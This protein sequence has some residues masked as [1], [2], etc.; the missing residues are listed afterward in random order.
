MIR[1]ARTVIVGLLML[2]AAPLAACAAERGTLEIVTRS[3]VQVFSVEV[4][5]TDEER[6]RGLMFRTSL[7]EG[8][9]M[10]F[11]FAPEQ[12]VTMWMKNT[13]IPLDMLFIR[14][15]GRIL[16]IAE[17]TKTESEDIIPSGGPV[18]AVVE[19]I[20]GSARKF[21]I[22]VGDKVAFGTMFKGH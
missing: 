8:Q 19:L 13:L 22:A 10:L 9:G 12:P 16:R 18:R 6:A 3:G 2:V 7:P 21:G 4:A 14:S 17:N 5:T 15:D 1:F 20:A 11:D